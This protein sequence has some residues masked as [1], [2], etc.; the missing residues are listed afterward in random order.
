MLKTF[1]LKLGP[2]QLTSIAPDVHPSIATFIALDLLEKEKDRHKA[3]ADSFKRDFE[4]IDPPK[5]SSAVVKEVEQILSH[6]I[7]TDQER[8]ALDLSP[9]ELIRELPDWLL[10][11]GNA[12]YDLKKY[13]SHEV[14]SVH[15][16]IIPD[17]GVIQFDTKNWIMS[18]K[19]SSLE[20][21]QFVI[22]IRAYAN[23]VEDH[24]IIFAYN[25]ID[26]P[27]LLE[28]EDKGISLP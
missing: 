20:C 25:D 21:H 2:S 7:S 23:K 12:S 4:I 3:E 9:R 13:L 14:R 8:V 19:V 24:K 18:H 17:N 1:A 27:P 11:D 6:T 16:D 22:T 26:P 15:V 5:R 10:S 28:S